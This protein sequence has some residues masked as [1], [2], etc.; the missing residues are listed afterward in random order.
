MLIK[1]IKLAIVCFLLTIS[2]TVSDS[3][4]KRDE[5]SPE[6][7]KDIYI[8]DVAAQSDWN[9]WVVGK[10][11]ENYFIKLENS[12]P[13]IICYKPTKESPGYS[14][15]LDKDG[16]PN[17]AVIEGHIFLFS[18]YKKNL[19]DI[20]AVLPNGEISVFRDVSIDFD[21]TSGF[22]NIS[23][24]GS[25]SNSDL[26]RWTG[27]ALGVAACGI[28]FVA[29][30]PTAGL[31]LTLAYIGCGATAVGIV[32]EILPQ[33]LKLITG[34]SSTTVGF[35]STAVGC[36][37][38]VNDLGMSCI[39]G[40]ASKEATIASVAAKDIENK[41]AQIN[42][43]TSQLTTGLKVTTSTITSIT[44]NSA[45]GG[46]NVISDGARPMIS[47]GVCWSISQNPTIADSKSSDG[48]ATG[49]FTSNIYGLVYNTN[50]YVRA[51][52]TNSAGTSYGAQ[53][54]FKSLDATLPTVS[55][56]SVD[57]ITLTLASCGGD[58]TSGGGSAVTARGV[59]WGT[60]QNP[61]TA[62]SHTSDG[63]GTGSFTSSLIGLAVGTT[64]HVRAYAINGVGIAYGSDRSFTTLVTP[65]IP[66]VTTTAI[67]GISQTSA[68]SGGNVTSIGSSDV[69]VR[70]LCWS[71]SANP[72]TTDNVTT[73]GAGIGS[74]TS[75]IV[76][77]IAG[78]TYHVRAYARNSSGIA[79]G[80]DRTFA[81]PPPISTTYEANN[82]LSGPIIDGQINDSEWSNSNAY[83]ITFT[84]K[85]G[86]DTQTGTLYLQHDGTW[87]Y[88]GVKTNTDS[89]WDAYLA[90]KFDGNHNH[91]LD[92]TSVEPH[93]DINIE[94]PSPDGWPEY[95]RYDYLLSTNLYPISQPIGTAS[96][97]YGSTNV[98]YEFKVKLSDLNI[99]SSR[100]IGF[101]IFNL[102]DPDPEHGYEFPT[103]SISTEPSKW[104][105]LKLQ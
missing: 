9:Y 31:S 82:S 2:I 46:G 65:T 54:N 15:F 26:I 64:Y 1:I 37:S 61:T 41:N 27:R 11:G 55:T 67:S 6:K 42:S 40:I 76:G 94:I 90:L 97:S 16:I 38:S 52:A 39:L 72:T 105:N 43:A 104:A 30:Y 49:S 99:G 84:R 13:S 69:I 71:I 92:G 75:N 78:T 44:Q 45:T 19:M 68:I 22:N 53:V 7:P 101:Y 87:L 80:S 51:Y 36:L 23:T 35:V 4:K 25:A 14:I 95:T 48:T 85:D 57:N 77:L 74:F 17:K 21:L 60:T 12:L 62:N 3:C 24:K 102:V 66:T 20:A 33:N 103:N 100:I 28:G 8:F 96:G 91:L 32:S 88:V 29:A 18:N 34:L 93:T 70:G 56:N 83:N 47:R 59:C 73:D 50:Y 86:Y 89:D 10:G 5:P 58:V 81:T 79:Y 98:N 63:T